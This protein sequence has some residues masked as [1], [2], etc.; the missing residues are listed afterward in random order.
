MQMI[1]MNGNSMMDGDPLT[2]HSMWASFPQYTFENALRNN[3]GVFACVYLQ[4][5]CFPEYA[6]SHNS[7][8]VEFTIVSHFRTVHVTSTLPEGVY[9]MLPDWQAAS[10]ICEAHRLQHAVGTCH[11]CN[12]YFASDW[13]TMWKTALKSRFLSQVGPAV[14]RKEPYLPQQ[15]SVGHWRTSGLCPLLTEPLQGRF[16]LPAV[17]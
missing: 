15:W 5:M 7:K 10:E 11:W 4:C 3:T 14:S 12:T 9:F 16:V 17:T 13:R 8:I 6:R 1:W 2:P